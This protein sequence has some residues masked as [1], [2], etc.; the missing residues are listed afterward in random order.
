[1]CCANK[2]TAKMEVVQQRDELSYFSALCFH[3]F[4][5]IRS[6]FRRWF[7]LSYKTWRHFLF[8]KQLETD[9]LLRARLFKTAIKLI[10]D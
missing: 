9:L 5:S 3:A 10:T 8:A 2:L 7:K 1:M 4:Y 6:N